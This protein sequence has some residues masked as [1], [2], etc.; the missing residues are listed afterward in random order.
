MTTIAASVRERAMC[1][2][3]NCVDGDV[4]WPTNKV[5]EINGALVGC[6]G[7]VSACNQ[8]MDWYKDT[9]QKKPK[10]I[11]AF[12]ALVLTEQGLFSWDQ[13]MVPEKIERGFHAVGTGASA[14]LGAILAGKEIGAAVEIAAQV[15]PNSRPPFF[16]QVLP[17]ANTAA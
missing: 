17:H 14:A 8:F 12:S 15:D 16:Y 7:D 2:D 1:S 3:A 5:F 6:A 9:T 11:G 4:W 10:F 13:T